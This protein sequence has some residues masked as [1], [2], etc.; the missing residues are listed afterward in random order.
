MDLFPPE[1]WLEVCSHLPPEARR[2]LSSTHR[3]LHDI[4]RPLGFSEFTLYLYPYGFEPQKTELDDALERLRF[5]TSPRIAPHV[6]SCITSQNVHW[7][8]AREGRS[9]EHVL[10]NAFFER[11]PRFIA[12]ERL[13]ADYIRFTHTGIA[14]LCGLPAL[15]YVRVSG[16]TIA[17]P[18]HMDS[19]LT[20]RVAS[21]ATGHDYYTH[22]IW[23]FL[24]SRETLR[25]LDLFNTSPLARAEV[26]PFP[27][28]H[29]L[30]MN[31]FLDRSHIVEIFSKFPNLRSFSNPYGDVIDVTQNLTPAQESSIFPIL[32]EYTGRHLNLHIFAQRATLTHITFCSGLV[33]TD[34][35]TQLQGITALPNIASLTVPFF[36]SPRVGFGKA[37]FETLLSFFPNLA[38]LH[39]TLIDPT[40]HGELLTRR[41]TSFLKMLPSSPLPST[42]HSLSLNWRFYSYNSDRRM[43]PS[44]LLPTCQTSRSCVPSSS[45][46]V[47]LWRA[48]FLMDITSCSCG[49]KRR[50]C[51]RRLRILIATQK[52]FGGSLSRQREKIRSTHAPDTSSL[53]ISKAYTQVRYELHIFVAS[54]K[55]D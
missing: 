8:R 36:T 41:M 9:G 20:L 24:L 18:E 16:R 45:P 25:E 1:L 32:K 55:R 40:E 47:P 53:A 17:T 12:L 35:F 50:P 13:D 49:R 10:I 46:S 22:D 26:P 27:N 38:E 51:G 31:G 6:R 14:S 4:S 52:S 15:T 37:E 19:A 30:T 5:W 34:L 54:V 7:Q 23:F 21:F 28:V 11:L 33:F 29:S 2:S 3:V 43:V 48:Y 44:L 42:L 39:L